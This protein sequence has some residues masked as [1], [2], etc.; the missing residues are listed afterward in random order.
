M[1]QYIGYSTHDPY[2][3]ERKYLRRTGCQP[4]V[5][6]CRPEFVLSKSHPLVRYSNNG[7]AS[8]LLVT[9]LLNPDDILSGKHSSSNCSIEKAEIA[10]PRMPQD[11]L[12]PK[13]G[14][15]RPSALES[16]CPHCGGLIERFDQLGF[17]YGWAIGIEPPYWEE[18]RQHVFRRDD[19]S[20][21]KCRR[22]LP[23]LD[24]R[25]HHIQ[26]KE[27]GGTDSSKNLVTQ[28]YYCHADERPI[29][30]EER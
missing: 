19:Y 10:K 8:I 27:E 20:C 9:H 26:P 29:F 28:C 22:R 21:Q 11:N 18:L 15:G 30:P 12:I 5:I 7:G 6:V 4:T 25:C 16:I 17:W 14:R 23:M 13:H 2:Q 24:L 1:A 3:A